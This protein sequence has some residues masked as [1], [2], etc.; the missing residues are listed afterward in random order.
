MSSPSDRPLSDAPSLQT[1]QEPT[2]PAKLFHQDAL[3]DHIRHSLA[4]SSS[5]PATVQPSHSV[6][7]LRRNSAG[8][9]S[10]TGRPSSS[11]SDRLRN[12]SNQGGVHNSG[13]GLG[14]L[15]SREE[16]ATKV[17][18]VGAK[19][20]LKKEESGVVRRRDGNVL[21]RGCILKTGKLFL[22]CV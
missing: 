15:Q 16:V 18:P 22:S 7:D 3:L 14:K 6:Q 10:D 12:V 11:K 17:K 4:S 2:T 5:A 13:Q 20:R 8:S 21:V 19:A 1:S 9:S